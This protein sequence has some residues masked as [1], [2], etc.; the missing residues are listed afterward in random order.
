MEADMKLLELLY[1]NEEDLL[2]TNSAKWGEEIFKPLGRE[3]GQSHIP[4]I[5]I[6]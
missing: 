4:I 1:G 6:G 3:F 5:R 2:S